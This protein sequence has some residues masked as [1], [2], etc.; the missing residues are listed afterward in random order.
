MYNYN[1]S[2]H[3]VDMGRFIADH[4]E[5]GQEPRAIWDNLE[6]RVSHYKIVD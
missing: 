4:L 2:D 3:C 6:A 5:Q 1:N